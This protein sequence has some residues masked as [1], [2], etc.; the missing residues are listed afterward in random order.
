MGTKIE[1]LLVEDNEDDAILEICELRKGGFDVV[2]ER[3][4][5][6]AE[7]REA[8]C[9]K[10]WDCIISDYS[11][12]HFSGIVALEI[13]K[14]TK[15]DI[16]FILVSGAI[17][18][19]IAVEAMK[20][21]A[22]D[23][24]MKN[25]LM[26]LVPSL[27]R[28]LKEAEIRKK[29][30]AS[31]KERQEQ[32]AMFRM[33][34]EK[35]SNIISIINEEGQLIFENSAVEKITGYTIEERKG[36]GI[37][38]LVHPDDL[39]AVKSN[40]NDLLT[41]PEKPR[42]ITIR[43]RHKDGS[44]RWMEIVSTNLLHDPLIKA[45]VV[46]IQDVTVRKEAEEKIRQSEISLLEAQKIAKLGNWEYFFLTKRLSFSSEA[47]A[48]F[49]IPDDTVPEKLVSLVYRSIYPEDLATHKKLIAEAVRNRTDYQLVYRIK[50]KNGSVKYL[51]GLG[52]VQSDRS[53]KIVSLRGT[54]QDIT[55][56][57]KIEQELR[58][59]EAELN[60]AQEMAQMGSWSLEME[61]NKVRLSNNFCRMLDLHPASNEIGF[62]DFKQLI[63]P[64]DLSLFNAKLEE[65]LDL[66]KPVNA[67][68]RLSVHNTAF[69][70]VRMQIVAEYLASNVQSI[71][72]VCV[73]VTEKKQR[74]QELIKLSKAIEQSPV[75][76]VITDLDAT[77]E[78]VNPACVR[79]TGYS[80]EE[81]IGSNPRILNS[82]KQD[83]EF[84]TRMYS[85]ITNGKLWEGVLINKNKKGDF[86]WEHMTINP[87]FDETGKVSNYLSIALDITQSKHDEQMI[88][89]LNENLEQRIKERTAQLAD[90]NKKLLLE[91]EERILIEHDLMQS[92]NK[93][94]ALNMTK[95][96]FFSIIA[97]DLKNPFSVLFT[98]ADLLLNYLQKD[99][100]GKVNEKA[101][102]IRHASKQGYSLLQNLLE[103]AQ[104]QIGS[105]PFAPT[106]LSLS[107]L[108]SST[109]NIV[110][111]QAAGKNISIN[112][113]ISAEISLLADENLLKI[114]LRNLVTNAIKFTPNNG[115]IMLSARVVGR[116]AEIH[117]ADSGIGIDEAIKEKLFRIDA[118][119][120]QKGTN[121]E[122][123]TGLGLILCKEFVS[124]H[125][126]EIWVES[127]KGR[128]STFIFTIPLAF[129]DV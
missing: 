110:E 68:L 69:I 114:I 26:R 67:D 104:T 27:E 106:T 55:E 94:K 92:E 97:H 112:N 33:L 29:L 41:E 49:E 95:D 56:R 90:A 43:N 30:K 74:K 1:V 22:H 36:C 2:Y 83:R 4:E 3:V 99:N 63:Y 65:L 5:N 47:Y 44:W 15:L 117:V 119:V 126:G 59:R 80:R 75:S 21:G 91:I 70:W 18:E 6:E 107:E 122:S 111:S 25:K 62:D 86:Y 32:D 10:H 17:G 58:S 108:V 127:E 20:A 9:A 115:F 128:G 23:Y 105:L 40:F 93:L 78:Y 52:I 129:E 113:T 76:I 42:T 77:I 81:L 60:K 102:M 24:I 109:L 79:L 13:F 31:E 84:F 54:I 53:G 124:K 39:E 125:G 16:P 50:T 8:L 12:P 98:S 87:I 89:E 88:R 100:L 85:L 72:G 73:D 120:T 96:K 19:D 71:K 48:I 101:Q 118:K 7:M 66:S 123:G 121:E 38:D 64:E 14:E 11:L 57:V 45:I 61:T 82:G 34:I 37:L 35:N 28:E 103:W 116:N 51:N 46:N